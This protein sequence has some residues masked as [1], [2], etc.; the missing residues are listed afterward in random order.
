MQSLKN[1]ALMQVNLY[2]ID[3]AEPFEK[4]VVG[5]ELLKRIFEENN[6]TLFQE[7]VT[8]ANGHPC[9]M[10]EYRVWHGGIRKFRKSAKC[11]CDCKMHGILCEC[12]CGAIVRMLV[13]FR[14]AEVFR[15]PN[16][17]PKK[18]YKKATTLSRI[19]GDL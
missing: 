7:A 2:Q 10:N 19:T 11:K 5:R 17:Q 15:G 13:E 9:Q 14:E 12:S 18:I 4:E 16:K 6:A 3:R 8:I 1:I